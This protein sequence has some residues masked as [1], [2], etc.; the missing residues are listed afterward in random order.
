MKLIDIVKKL[1]GKSRE[2]ARHLCLKLF[3]PFNIVEEVYATGVNLVLR[4]NGTSEKHIVLG[5]H[6]DTVPGCPG[7]NDNFSAI[8]VL[9][10]VAQAFGK[11]KL[12]HGL[13]LCIFDE[14]E[15][16]CLGS[17]AYVQQ[18]GVHDIKAM[19]DLEL[20][21]NG[22]V[23]GLWPVRRET[24]LLHTITKTLNK[25]KQAYETGGEL[26]MFYA[27]YV[28]FRGAGTDSICISLIPKNEVELIRPFVT[29]NRFLIGLKIALG[30]MKI[31]PFFKTYHATS[32]TADKLNEKSLQLAKDVVLDIVKE[33]QKQ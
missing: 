19:V 23:I 10:G 13:T 32:D 15:I 18:H 7:A 33:F 2:D 4:K 28:P 3:A 16:D 1:E 30:L 21:G 14:E 17:R 27:D 26:P 6:Y 24:P 29:Q 20:V 5:A 9:Y 11:K 8:A 25:R 22:S 31:P 12:K